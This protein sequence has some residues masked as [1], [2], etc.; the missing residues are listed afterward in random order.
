[1][2][3]TLLILLFITLLMV[4]TVKNIEKF[5]VDTKIEYVGCFKDKFITRGG[6]R[7]F[8]IEKRGG[9]KTAQEC[10]DY[11]I[12][13]N[14]KYFALQWPRD[15]KSACYVGARNDYP[16]EEME[17]LEDNRC[18]TPKNNR[19]PGFT[20]GGGMI[21]SVY[22]IKELT[23]SDIINDIIES[24]TETEILNELQS[25]TIPAS[26]KEQITKVFYEKCKF[27]PKSIQ[28]GFETLLA[29]K[30]YCSNDDHNKSFGG[31]FCSKDACE[32]KCNECRDTQMCRWNIPKPDIPDKEPKPIELD[33]EIKNNEVH[34]TW[35][36]P[37]SE[38][39]VTNYSVLITQLNNPDK[40]EIEI[41]TDIESD[42][43]NH[44]IRDLNPR[45][46]YFIEAYARN[47]Y[48]Y[49]K[50]SNKIEV[51]VNYEDN[52]GY[53]SVEPVDPYT[54]TSFQQMVEDIKKSIQEPSEE[55]PSETLSPLKI[56]TE[57]KNK[58][59]DSNSQLN[60]DLFFGA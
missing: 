59:S 29:C 55:T 23:E 34:L 50:A 42:F 8:A 25:N 17:R 3:N 28:G 9:V 48:G 24:K 40:L 27:N 60:L 18:Q 32:T 10:K 36:K 41:P 38:D 30:D 56:L 12:S 11:A 51:Q 14:K 4:F 46:I 39:P 45:N 43:V 15:D 33:Y 35:E 1:M 22:E 19:D 57:L 31:V 20:H 13:K 6:D 44:V 52:Q 2:Y 47:K 53:S 5:E 49:S 7:L 54:T 37:Q 16:I 58:D 21:N 26:Q